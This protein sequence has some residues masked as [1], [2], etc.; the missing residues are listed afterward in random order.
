MDAGTVLNDGWSN[1]YVGIPY[2]VGGRDESG[3]DCWGLIQLVYEREL[4][5]DLTSYAAPP[6]P[7]WFERVENYAAVEIDAWSE[8]AVP[9][10]ADVLLFALQAHPCHC[11]LWLG[12][13]RFLHAYHH[14]PVGVERLN[15]SWANRH[16][17]TYR[18][19]KRSP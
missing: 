17:A 12:G 9:V 5:I 8:I 18:H 6:G 16:I 10:Q 7:G 4:G 1:A 19:R 14:H 3:V 15:R 13:G 11:G 2:R